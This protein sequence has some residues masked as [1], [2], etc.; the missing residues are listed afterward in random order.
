MLVL[1]GKVEPFF[2][3][4]I[5][6]FVPEQETKLCGTPLQSLLFFDNVGDGVV[7]AVENSQNNKKKKNHSRRFDVLQTQLAL[8]DKEIILYLKVKW[9]VF[10]V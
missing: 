2:P 7:K 3:L 9:N 4:G 6:L 8:Y 5:A 1:I 10:V